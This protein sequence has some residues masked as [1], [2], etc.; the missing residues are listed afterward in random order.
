MEMQ[1]GQAKRYPGEDHQ[2]Y[3][4]QNYS[5]AFKAYFRHG[6]FSFPSSSK[7][8]Q[9]TEQALREETVRK[10]RERSAYPWQTVFNKP[11]V[12]VQEK[13]PVHPAEPGPPAIGRGRS[14][15]ELGL[16]YRFHHTLR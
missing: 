13:K 14:P 11:N 12:S 3:N 9:R 15:T 10:P 8:P 16:H 1:H 7:I 2:D 6:V 4:Q 5:P